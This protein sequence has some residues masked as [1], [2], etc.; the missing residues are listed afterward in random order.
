MLPQPSPSGTGSEHGRFTDRRWHMGF[1]PEAVEILDDVRR[2]MEQN[3]E[4]AHSAALRLV[5]ILTP[6]AETASGGARGGLAPWQK[7]KV[8]RYLRDHLTRTLHVEEIANQVSLSVSYF[9]RAFKDSFGTTPHTH[10]I[11]LRLEL[12]Q[13][14]MLTTEDPLSHIALACGMADQA[15][16]SKLFRRNVG[17]SPCAWRRRN[18]TDSEAEA[19]R[20]S[21][22]ASRSVMRP[23]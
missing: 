9:C 14:L 5:T 3:P 19:R 18:L 11:R 1:P 23:Q 22:K 2:A 4:N 17:E 10:L 21:L 12:A 16:L 15:H 6:P 7:R 20:R 8:D 13:R